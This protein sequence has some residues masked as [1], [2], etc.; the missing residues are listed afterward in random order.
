MKKRPT[1]TFLNFSG[2]LKAL[3]EF[4]KLEP[5]CLKIMKKIVER[6]KNANYDAG[7]IN[8]D[9]PSNA[10]FDSKRRSFRNYFR[11]L[12]MT[13]LLC[14]AL[15]VFYFVDSTHATS[16][17]SV[18]SFIESK[19]LKDETNSL[20]SNLI[21]QDSG[22]EATDKRELG[23]QI[24]SI[25]ERIRQLESEEAIPWKSKGRIRTADLGGRNEEAE[26]EELHIAEED[27]DDDDGDD[28]N[29]EAEPEYKI[30]EEESEVEEGEEEEEEE[31]DG[32]P[33]EDGESKRRKVNLFIFKYKQSICL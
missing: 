2:E 25:P 33:Q 22:E 31:E 20:I 24:E 8:S 11:Y 14:T 1:P 15:T 28:A 29:K 17:R 9:D 26:E 6:R 21:E 7:R 16:L 23:A 12:L 19:P 27:D 13:A 18:E 30:F 3:F 4:E 32:E 10:Q 5:I